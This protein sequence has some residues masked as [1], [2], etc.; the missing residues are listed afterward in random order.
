MQLLQSQVIEKIHLKELLNPKQG[1]RDLGVPPNI[2]H[3]RTEGAP[4][5]REVGELLGV[6]EGGTNG[7]W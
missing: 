2:M 5:C 6:R 7:L 1:A 3:W 4:G